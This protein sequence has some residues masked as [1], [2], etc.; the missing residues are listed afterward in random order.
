MPVGMLLTLGKYL[1][2]ALLYLFVVLVLRALISQAL[3]AQ[4]RSVP[5]STRHIPHQAP[6]RSTP[7]AVESTPVPQAAAAQATAPPAGHVLDRLDLG[8]EHEVEQ[9]APPVQQARAPVLVVR[10]SPKADLPPGQAYLLTATVTLGRGPCNTIVLPDRYVS[11]DHAV[12]Y[13]RE[14]RCLLADQG[15][16]NGTYHNGTRI[17][18]PV[19]LSDGD[20]IAVGA[21]AFRYQA[22]R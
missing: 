17:A 22:A 13:L 21:T 4:H 5:S 18:D 8:T 3:A 10:R 7:T 2:V 16:T 19:S 6:S 1:F 20:E 15:S 14:G 9:L 12:I 11:N